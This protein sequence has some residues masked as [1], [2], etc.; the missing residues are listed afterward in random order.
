MAEVEV[1][2]GKALEVLGG[3]AVDHSFVVGDVGITVLIVKQRAHDLSHPETILL[4]A[5]LTLLNHLFLDFLE[6]LVV[7]TFL[8]ALLDKV[9]SGLLNAGAILGS[10]L[11]IEHPAD[12]T[13]EI[14]VV[15]SG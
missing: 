5:S 11:E 9:D 1:A 8:A 6:S 4:G 7:A 13:V 2:F 15:T 14:D 10:A 3:D 12:T